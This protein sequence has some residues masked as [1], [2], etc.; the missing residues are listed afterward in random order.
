MTAP[1][2]LLRHFLG[3][4]AA[5]TSAEFALVVPF[6][7][8]LV[9]GTIN[10]GLAMSAVNQIHYAAERS[11]RCLSVD[12]SDSCTGDVD[13]Y[14]K[15]LYH[16]PSVSGLSFVATTQACGNEVTGSGEYELLAGMASTSFSIT[17]RACYPLI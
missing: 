6:F 10:G 12:V 9:F 15:Q 16:G 5:V 1:A 4:T 17:A 8:V 11:A 14:A 3:N 13:T 2:G 7:L